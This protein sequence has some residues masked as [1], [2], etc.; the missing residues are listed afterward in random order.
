M[1]ISIWRARPC[2]GRV[3]APFFHWITRTGKNNSG[4]LDRRT[5]SRR[6]KK[7]GE[8]ERIVRMFTNVFTSM[9]DSLVIDQE[10]TWWKEM[11][12]KEKTPVCSRRLDARDEDNEDREKDWNRDL[13][14]CKENRGT[15]FNWNAFFIF[16]FFLFFSKNIIVIV[17]KKKRGKRGRFRQNYFT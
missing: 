15:W 10:G 1:E 16:Y 8:K 9:N 4:E 17:S 2:V 6:E 12:L 7:G 3:C 13:R 11:L 5:K 14:Q